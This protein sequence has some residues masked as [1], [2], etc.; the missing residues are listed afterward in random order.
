M[1][2]AREGILVIADVTG[3]T[4][5]LSQSELEHAEDSLRS[6]LQL[7]IEHTK[8]PLVVSRLQGD[9]VISYALR[10]RVLQGQ[11]LVDQIEACYVGFRQ[12]RERMIRNT[13][14]P[15]NACRNIPNLDLKFFVHAGAFVLQ[16][17]ANYT[18]LVGSDVNLIHRLAKNSVT[19]DTG[20]RAY[21]LYTQQAIATLGLAEMAAAMAPHAERYE[22]LGEVRVHVQDLHAVW[23]RERVRHRVVVEPE[24]A[25]VVVEQRLAAAPALAWDYLTKPEY[26]AILFS[27]DR[28]SVF[29]RPHGRVGPGA[30]YHCAHGSKTYSHTILD[31]QP[32]DYYTYQETRFI[33]PGCRCLITIRLIPRE[34]GT[35]VACICG[36]LQGPL[37]PRLVV[38]AMLRRAGP[39]VFAQ[40][41]QALA[42]RIETDLAAQSLAN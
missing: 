16:P 41:L 5:Y 3:Y 40:G 37:V 29:S 2:P 31:W 1:T 32:F 28:Q 14:C 8:P 7:I 17:L 24:Q 33:P 39:R 4:A 9:A 18:E 11:S 23:E 38:N 35:Q 36:K 19:Q 13:S 15:C 20:I 30:V 42:K 26:R 12:A 34:Q 10:D 6:L 25:L 21:A 27:S 22:H